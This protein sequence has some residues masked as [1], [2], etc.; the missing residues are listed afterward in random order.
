MDQ[1]GE[2]DAKA[3]RNPTL[4]KVL[5]IGGQESHLPTLSE[6]IG[7]G[8][9]AGCLPSSLCDSWCVLVIMTDPYLNDSHP[10]NH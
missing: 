1:A 8:A 6:G 10:R 9:G 5:S 3:L 7:R 4:G 2:R